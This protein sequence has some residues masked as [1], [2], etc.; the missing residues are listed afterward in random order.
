MGTR[1]LGEIVLRY[2]EEQGLLAVQR[3]LREG[4]DPN[5]PAE[6]STCIHF[7]GVAPLYCAASFGYVQVVE[8][9]ADA[10][11]DLGWTHPDD[12]TTALH[13]AAYYGNA[14]MVRSLAA[15]GGQAAVDAR[16]NANETPLH[17][18]AC[19]GGGRPPAGGGRLQPFIGHPAAAQALLEAGAD[20]SPKNT[21]G[22]TALDVAV[23][24]GKACHSSLLRSSL[25]EIAAC[26]QH[27]VEQARQR[28]CGARQ[29]L[30]LATAMLPSAAATAGLAGLPFDMLL[31]VGEALAALGSPRR[32]GV[33]QPACTGMHRRR[34]LVM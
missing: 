1:N 20:T 17:Q 3:Q 9:L 28:L 25:H 21:N 7:A 8:A 33:V 12:G 30:A 29:R 22:E 4:A 23:R 2:Q 16:N 6:F 5:D 10:G 11:A 26:I 13:A 32:V 34:C 24:N 31:P 18:A 19:V 27:A 14:V 15:R